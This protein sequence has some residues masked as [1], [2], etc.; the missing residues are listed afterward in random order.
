MSHT[1]A[2]FLYDVV[3]PGTEDVVRDL[4]LVHGQR[5]TSLLVVAV[6]LAGW[7]ASGAMISLM[8]G[9][10][11]IYQIPADPPFLRER[12]IALSAGVHRR[13]LPLW[14]A[15]ALIVFGNG[16]NAPRSPGFGFCRR[17][18]PQRMGV[19]CRAS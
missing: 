17:S 18:G 19:A 9:F 16:W 6:V 4:F 10:D 12:G 5:P 7:A 11:A 8:E 13:V 2:R 3:P 1:I 14:G 15:S